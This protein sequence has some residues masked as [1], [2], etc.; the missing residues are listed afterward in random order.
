MAKI[1]L[2]LGIALT[3]TGVVLAPPRKAVGDETAQSATQPPP[4]P[5]PPMRSVGFLIGGAFLSS[6]GT[7]FITGGAIEVAKVG[8]APRTG[9]ARLGEG[10]DH[11]VDGLLGAV[12]IGTGSVCVL[13]GVPFIAYG[14]TPDPDPSAWVTSKR[15]PSLVAPP[16]G[17]SIAF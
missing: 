17:V 2:V 11:L 1:R 6:F 9:V 7:A 15:N 8:P 3:C 16:V 5:R 10:L 14:A 13:V 4:K 12:L